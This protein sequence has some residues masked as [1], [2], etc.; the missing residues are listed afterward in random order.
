MT[1]RTTTAESF[2]VAA[3]ASIEPIKGATATSPI[4]AALERAK[5]DIESLTKSVTGTQEAAGVLDKRVEELRVKTT[6]TSAAARISEAQAKKDKVATAR[7]VTNASA[8]AQTIATAKSM[9]STL[10]EAAKA[11]SSDIA[12]LKQETERLERLLGDVKS[13]VA[14]V[15]SAADDVVNSVKPMDAIKSSSATQIPLST[16]ATARNLAKAAVSEFVTGYIAEREKLLREHAIRLR[17]ILAPEVQASA[18]STP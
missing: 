15:K 3:Q 10:L 17:A 18:A 14:G 13:A 11:A 1:T 12:K 2:R 9:V 4:Q 6:G 8:A 16:Y 5:S 7:V